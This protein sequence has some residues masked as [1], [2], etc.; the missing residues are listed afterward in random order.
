M[1]HPGLNHVIS[2]RD[3]LRNSAVGFGQL[4]LASLLARECSADDVTTS[5]HGSLAAR[6]SHIPAR[7]K[8]VIFCFMQGG[9]SHVDTFDHKPLLTRDENKPIPLQN[10]DGNHG[11]TGNILKPFWRF[12]KY[13]QCGIEVS[14]LFPH[15]ARCVDDICFI[16]SMRTEGASHFPE[17]MRLHTGSD[18]LI[19]PTLGSWVL[20]GLG[21]ENEN[22]PGFI[23]ICPCYNFGSTTLLRGA[24]LPSTYQMVPIGRS[25]AISAP[26]SFREARFRNTQNPD[27]PT[28]L[29]RKQLDFVAQMNRQHLSTTG[30]DAEL[31]GRIA[32]FETAF[33]MQAAAPPLLD[34][35]DETEETLQLYGVD[36]P[37]ET[38]NYA[39]QCL[40][41]R[42]LVERGVRF[43]ELFHAPSSN[44]SGWDQHNELAKYHAS[45]AREVDRPI[46]AL[47]TDLKRRGLLDQT[48]VVW[49]GEFGRSPG[50]EVTSKRGG[51]DHHPW[52]F[53][54]WLAGGGVKGGIQYGRTD[55]YGYHAVE[56]P[57][58]F[59]DL[60]AT[61]L[62]LLG[63]DHRQL[64]FRH[65]S[66]DVRLTDALN[67]L[68]GHV[69][70]DIIA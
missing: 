45:H 21:T 15:I 43:V 40:L 7:A 50:A 2:R 11:R 44:D 51:R 1:H 27:L 57:V 33:R 37:G 55:E 22:L 25:N 61:I 6:P 52:G 26:P 17:Q 10:V 20:Y 66:E 39:R 9:P 48:L 23:T 65:G 60:H 68:D 18:R 56:N 13:G 53:T 30:P 14:D 5:Q 58:N 19:R 62:Y 49:G 41:A 47:I 46:A 28:H 42:R 36:A 16:H 67:G 12:R 38:E 24:F 32:S 3:A 29:Q 64:I 59:H 54:F 8:S 69:I 31:E 35:S 4:A 63:L 34:Y 70:R